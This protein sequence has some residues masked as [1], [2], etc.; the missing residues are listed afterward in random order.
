MEDRRRRVSL[1]KEELRGT[2]QGLST[3]VY[4]SVHCPVIPGDR[5]RVGPALHASR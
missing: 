3:S 2:S 4:T 5:R 1:Q